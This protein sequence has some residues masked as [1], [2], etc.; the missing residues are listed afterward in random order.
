M[1]VYKWERYGCVVLRMLSNGLWNTV[2]LSFWLISRSCMILFVIN[3]D[4]Q[5]DKCTTCSIKIWIID[6]ICVSSISVFAGLYCSVKFVVW[7]CLRC[8][9]MLHKTFCDVENYIVLQAVVCLNSVFSGSKHA[10]VYCVWKVMSKF[11]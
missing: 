10:I 9:K 4:M 7:V 5:D 11:C 3:W 1:N 2:Y 8:L 6:V